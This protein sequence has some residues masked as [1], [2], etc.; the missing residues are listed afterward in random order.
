[1]LTIGASLLNARF[2]TGFE[3]DLDAIEIYQEN[4]EMHEMNNIEVICCDIIKQRALMKRFYKQFDTVI[5]NPPF[6]TK[7]NAGTDVK[8]LEIAFELTSGTVY[9][10]HKSS[11]RWGIRFVSNCEQCSSDRLFF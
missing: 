1:M 9:S 8:F 4:N 11:T 3:L 10:L 2:V 7:H 6:G 5:M